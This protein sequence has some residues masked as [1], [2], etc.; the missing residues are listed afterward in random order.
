MKAGFIVKYNMREISF[1]SV[2]SMRIPVH[3]IYLQQELY[4]A[5]VSYETPTPWVGYCCDNHNGLD[6]LIPNTA[7]ERARARA[8]VCVFVCVCVRVC[9][10]VW[11][12]R[13]VGYVL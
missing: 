6:V 9:V 2:Q 12:G 13:W 7:R 1:S 8:R 5:Y 4:F 3:Q 10:C 11:E